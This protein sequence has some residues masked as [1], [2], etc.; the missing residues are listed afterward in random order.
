AFPG[1]SLMMGMIVFT[2]ANPT[3]ILGIPAGLAVIGLPLSL[4]G[5]LTTILGFIH[6]RQLIRS[7]HSESQQLLSQT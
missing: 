1:L 2:P 3:S 6:T 4:L 5:T 7:G